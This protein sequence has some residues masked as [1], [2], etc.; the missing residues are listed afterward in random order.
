MNNYQKKNDISDEK[1]IVKKI[2]SYTK[3]AWASVTVGFV[4]MIGGLVLFIFASEFKELNL[5]GDFYGGSVASIWALSGVFFIYVAFLGQKLQLINQQTEIK[6]TRDEIKEQRDVMKSQSITLKIQ[7][8]DNT[9]FNMLKI[10][11]IIVENVSYSENISGLESFNSFK[12]DFD[13]RIQELKTKNE[14]SIQNCFSSYYNEILLKEIGHYCNNFH[15]ILKFITSFNF[16]YLNNHEIND[17]KN[18][19]YSIYFSQ[20]SNSELTIL[21]YWMKD[22]DE[23]FQNIIKEYIY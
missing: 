4:I 16:K 1:E 18:E 9:F 21:F 10:H 8:F 12:R 3:F 11:H 20:M 6:L 13:E 14:P 15:S 7:Q 5:L 23:Y 2:D 22:R 17:L 19:Y